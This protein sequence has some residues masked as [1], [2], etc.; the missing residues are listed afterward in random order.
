M[1]FFRMKDK[2]PN[3]FVG[4]AAR[5]RRRQQLQAQQQMLADRKT[6]APVAEDLS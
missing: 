3:P 5:D 1:A 4:T 2:Q 6:P